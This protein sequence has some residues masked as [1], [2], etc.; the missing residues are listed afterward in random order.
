MKRLREFFSRYE[1]VS[2]REALLWIIVVSAGIT[3]MWHRPGCAAEQLVEM[4]MSEDGKS[5][6]SFVVGS[7]SY[8]D[9]MASGEFVMIAEGWRMNVTGAIERETCEKGYGPLMLREHG[10][11]ANAHVWVKDSGTFGDTAATILCAIVPKKEGNP[12]KRTAFTF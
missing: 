6:L 11:V 12:F 10:R 5:T 4:D 8:K 3:I 2:K 9:G 1:W 7:A